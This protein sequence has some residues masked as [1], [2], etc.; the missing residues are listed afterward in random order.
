MFIQQRN[1]VLNYFL[2]FAFLISQTGC[3]DKPDDFVGPSWDMQINLPLT[4][5]EYSLLEIVEK[6]S[7]VLNSSQD[8]STLGLIYFGDTHAVSTIRLED[9]LKIDPFN[10]E[11]SQKIG[12]LQIKYSIPAAS[13]V[14]VEEWTTDVNSGSYQ[15]FPEQEGDINIEIAGIETVESLSADE[16][17]LNLIVQN[18]LPVPIQ[19]RGLII[20]NANDGSQESIIEVPGNNPES[21]INISPGLF[22]S[23]NYSIDGKTITNNLEYIG[24][25]YSI[26]SNGD[27]VQIPEVAGTTILALFEDLIISE[28]TAPLPVQN[29]Q[30]TQSSTI[31]DSTFIEEGLIREGRALLVANNNIDVDLRADVIFNNLF[32]NTGN[33]Y[34]LS[35]PLARNEKNKIVELNSLIDWTVSTT[36]PGVPTNAITYTINVVT[37]ST[38]EISTVNKND[39]VLFALN[40]E[41]LQFEKFSG[42][43]K[44]IKMDLENTGVKLE[45]DIGSDK[46]NFGKLNFKDAVFYLNFNSSADLEMLIN[47]EIFAS[48]GI[49]KR[50][51]Q[52][53]DIIIPELT[54]KKI[55]ISDLINEFENVLPDSFSIVGSSLLNPNYQSG[56]VSRGDSLFGT[57]DFEIPLNVGIAQASYKDTFE[58]DL[59]DV[60]EDDI[61]QVNYGEVTLA[62]RNAIPVG[63]TL[64]A[65]V[66]D[67]VNNIILKIP[68]EYND[69]TFVEVPKPEM[70]DAGEVLLASEKVQILKL[71]GEDIKKFLKNPFMAIEVNFNTAGED[72]TPV[73]FRTFNKIN[74]DIRA[75]ADYRVEL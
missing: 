5:K 7:S 2:I 59:G 39:S 51:M 19:L 65:I 60:S 18:N 41:E 55:D 15:I 11:F 26:G 45:Y 6:D 34:Q 73:K 42:I 14:Q 57:I 28:A 31:S 61:D 64:T 40:F 3:F 75:T 56:S 32:D 12:A 33:Q 74:I 29:F 24:T 62:I 48:N 43:L 16:G 21:W 23:E 30:F 67:S 69:I 25:I 4:K 70:S 44:P 66:L 54:P 1:L 47:G 17:K 68:T 63:L 49:I 27:S 13:E 9:E 38:G 72:N 37:D 36:N 20:R 35:I 10:T 8:P 52:I 53:G 50:S 71:V 46:L 22:W 58:I